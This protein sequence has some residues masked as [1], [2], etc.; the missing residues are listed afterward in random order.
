[1]KPKLIKT[2]CFIEMTKMKK[3]IKDLVKEYFKKRPPQDLQHGPVVDWVEKQYMKLYGKNPRDIWRSIRKLHEDGILIKVRKGVYCYDPKAIEKHKHDT[4]T[5]RQKEIIL[6]RD[7]YKCVICRKGKK[8]GVELHIDH[9]KTLY[10]GGKS[11][12]RNGQTLCA[13]HNLIKK[14]INQTEVWKKMFIRLYKT[15]QNEGDKKLQ[16]FCEDILKVYEKYDINGHV[17]WEY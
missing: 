13:Q 3:T 15:A 5:Q 14:N 2:A 4:F 10:L 17:S 7:A 6:K 12:I 1:M 11:T 9:I 16:R 8:D